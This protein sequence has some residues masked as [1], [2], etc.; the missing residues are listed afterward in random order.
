MINLIRT[1]SKNP[2]FIRLNAVLDIELAIRDGKD[3]AF[4]AQYNTIDEI[5]Y[6]VLAYKNE[7][8]VGCGAIK[9]Y[10]TGTM[11]VKRMFV[12]DAQRGKGIA[13]KVLAELEKWAAELGFEKCIL[14]TGVKQP[15]AIQL[16]KKCG[17]QVIPN[18]GQYVAVGNSVCFEKS[19]SREGTPA[20][21]DLQ[22][23]S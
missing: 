9:F 3:H 12:P 6:M 20:L 17:Y 5:K 22:S 2:D 23:E 15:E 14:E 4:Y 18:Y 13:T 21:S 16:Y 10:E 1:N 7:E 8:P 11:E 19:L